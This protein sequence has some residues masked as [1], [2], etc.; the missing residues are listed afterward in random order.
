V[1]SKGKGDIFSTHRPAGLCTFCGHLVLAHPH[2]TRCGWCKNT[3]KEAYE[4]KL[5]GKTP[6]SYP[7]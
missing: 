1:S 7:V 4:A 3:P 6:P 2:D 5:A